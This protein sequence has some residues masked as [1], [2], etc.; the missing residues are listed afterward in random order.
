[1]RDSL[2]PRDSV[3][4]DVKGHRGRGPSRFLHVHSFSPGTRGGR[5][6]I[7]AFAIAALVIG[8]VFLALGLLLLTGLVVA[9]ALA[10]SGYLLWRRLRGALR[11]G[12][13][14]PPQRELELD[15][16]LEIRAPDPDRPGGRLPRD[17]R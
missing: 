5:A 16:S 13:G 6:R 8:G 11:R 1:M 10:G 12:S 9:G 2:E 14:A 7:I 17:L 4:V 3:P 15:P